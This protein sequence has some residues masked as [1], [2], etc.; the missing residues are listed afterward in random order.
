MNSK[1]KVTCIRASSSTSSYSTKTINT[2]STNLKIALPN[3]DVENIDDKLQLFS[4]LKQK[5]IINDEDHQLFD[6]NL[7]QGHSK[8][9]ID[10][11]LPSHN[12]HRPMH[13]IY[14]QN[15]GTI[16]ESADG[17]NSKGK[18]LTKH[19]R[20]CSTNGDHG[21]TRKVSKNRIKRQ[22][23]IGD[24]LQDLQ[25]LIPHSH[26]KDHASILDDAAEYIKSLKLQNE[27]ILEWNEKR[28]LHQI[29]YGPTFMPVM[30][31]PAMYKY[32]NSCRK[33]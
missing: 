33:F 13:G 2:P 3:L 16:L 24:I 9:E 1:Q 4:D 19:K 11:S 8:P 15:E 32:T 28:R 10:M 25:N 22:R 27:M 14:L 26:K 6:D 5:R 17:D 31:S 21:A 30:M 23:R 29:Q 20:S 12:D 18:E 7:F